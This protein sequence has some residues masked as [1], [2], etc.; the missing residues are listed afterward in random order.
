MKKQTIFLIAL[1]VYSLI[2]VFTYKYE[3]LLGDTIIYLDIAD[4]YVRG[5]FWNAVN[6]MWG[7]LFSWLLVPFLYFG[8]SHLF[9]VNALHVIIGCLTIA[10][11]KILSYRFEMS[12]KIRNIILLTLVPILLYGSLISP[13]DFLLLCILVYYLGIV[14]KDDYPDR[15][16]NGIL[17][18]VLGAFA[19]FAKPYGFPFII[20]HFLL[21][22]IVHYFKT[23]TKT[24]KKNTLR[25]AFAGIALFAVISGFWIIM[26]SSKYNDIAFSTAGGHNFAILGPNAKGEGKEKGL[27][28]FTEGF[29][30]PPNKTAS[31]VWEDATYL[32]V[33]S[34]SP[35]ASWS[36]FKY[37]ISRII[38]KN[39]SQL[40]KILNSFSALSIVIIIIY[41]LL[42][43]GP[44]KELLT[45][46][47][48]LLFPLLTIALYSGGYGVMH[49]EPR[50]L[51]L[52]NILLLMMGGHLLYWLFRYKFFNTTRKNI[53]IVFF[54][55]S[56]LVVPVRYVIHRGDTG[57]RIHALAAELKSRYNIEGKIASNKEY[58][59]TNEAWYNS[60]RLTYFLKTRYYGQAKEDISDS[61][62]ESEL[63]KYG[64]DYYLVWGKHPDIP[65]FLS[66]YK[67]VTGGDIPG[68]KIYSLKDGGADGR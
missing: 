55:L 68:L 32:H 65:R 13:H 3:R 41:I 5:D 1:L 34:W 63:K 8:S 14:F 12:D 54:V 20:S 30:E 57:E 29:F 50:Y 15:V 43:I 35:L 53:L 24:V 67:E 36:Y 37:F 62:L 60:Y 4:K 40:I 64:I 9:A 66:N 18:G 47:S 6:G 38:F 45:R 11:V 52:V 7:P 46:K 39:I 22:N 48:I 2:T 23:G 10:G 61:E 33:K 17:S 31:V 49:Y 59:P 26:I 44:F 58:V 42:C 25:N 56:F 51:W 21:V 16:H 19:Y 28:I 27:P